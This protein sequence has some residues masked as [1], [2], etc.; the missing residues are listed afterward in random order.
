M[1]LH[2]ELSAIAL[3]LAAVSTREEG[4]ELLRATLAQPSA[5]TA[6]P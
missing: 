3:E 6:L 5:Q 2:A 4:Y 1:T